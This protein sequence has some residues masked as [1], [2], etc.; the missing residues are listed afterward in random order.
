MS[1]PPQP[2][3]MSS[4]WAPM[5]RMFT[6]GLTT[7]HV[8]ERTAKGVLEALGA[9]RMDAAIPEGG[10]RI[11]VRGFSLSHGR[12]E[13]VQGETMVVPPGGT[14]TLRLALEAHDGTARP[15]RATLV[16]NGKRWRNLKDTTPYSI[17]FEDIP[18]SGRA[19]TYY[20]LWMHPRAPHRLITNPIFAAT[21]RKPAD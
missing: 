19:C 10:I 5:A 6:G 18:P 4:G 21:P 20:R 15:F 11:R 9:G 2:I 8:R 7:F 12:R 13:A 16:R 17:T 1:V 3:S 14:V